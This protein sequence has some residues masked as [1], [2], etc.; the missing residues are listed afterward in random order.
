MKK[1]TALFLCLLLG[2]SALA[3]CQKESKNPGC[4][5]IF[6]KIEEAI[7]E[8]A[9][10]PM[11]DIDDETLS[12]LYGIDPADV[13][14]DYRGALAQLNVHGDEILVLKVKEGKMAEAE[15][16]IGQRRDDLEATWSRYL[17]EVYEMVQ[18]ARVVKNGS[19]LLF[20]VS[21]KPEKAAAAFD[22]MT[23]A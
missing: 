2:L 21:E 9:L 23:K 19:Y 20:V 3:G 1:L 10:P 11:D 18:N 16:G 4:E 6:K 5:E 8:D 14:E 15:A 7:G 13:L 17:P 12:V 22:E